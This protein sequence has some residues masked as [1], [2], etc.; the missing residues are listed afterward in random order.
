MF[1]RSCHIKIADKSAL[2]DPATERRGFEGLQ[3]ASGCIAILDTDTTEAENKPD[4]CKRSVGD[5]ERRLRLWPGVLVQKSPRRGWGYLAKTQTVRGGCWTVAAPEK[6]HPLWWLRRLLNKDAR[7]WLRRHV[8]EWR[9]RRRRIIPN[10]RTVPARGI[11]PAK[12]TSNNC[13]RQS[14]GVLFLILACVGFFLSI[15]DWFSYTEGSC[16]TE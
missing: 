13:F 4:R 9:H 10:R 5:E 11:M 8:T 1:L 16:N 3:A 14:H 12:I 6:Q 15:V 2:L 7:Y